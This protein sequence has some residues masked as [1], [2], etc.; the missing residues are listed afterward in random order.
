MSKDKL[1]N[2]LI[3]AQDVKNIFFV[4]VHVQWMTGL[5]RRPFGV[6]NHNVSEENML[7]IEVFWQPHVL[8]D[9]TLKWSD[10]SLQNL[11]KMNSKGF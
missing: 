4:E 8:C 3:I 2:C 1:Q 11:L 6:R 10:P 5:E 9:Q 7:R